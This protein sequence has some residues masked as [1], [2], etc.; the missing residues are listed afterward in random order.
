MTC[1]GDS[2]FICGGP[3]ALTLLVLGSA[4]SKLNSHLNSKIISLPSGWSAASTTC[5]QEVLLAVPFLRSP[6]LLTT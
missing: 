6:M 4:V 2:S 5:I 3:D 1:A